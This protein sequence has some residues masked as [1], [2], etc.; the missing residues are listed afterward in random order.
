[1]P[2]QTRYKKMNDT[3]SNAVTFSYVHTLSL[4]TNTSNCPRPICSARYR[5]S[6]TPPP[7]GTGNP[8]GTFPEMYTRLERR[9]RDSILMQPRAAPQ[10]PRRLVSW[11]G[12]FRSTRARSPR[13][14]STTGHYPKSTLAGTRDAR[15]CPQPCAS[16]VPS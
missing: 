3:K 10:R 15:P 8:Q 9:H 11:W 12:P 6:E 14:Q 2:K 7:S 13:A 4:Q 16:L 1:V 5:R